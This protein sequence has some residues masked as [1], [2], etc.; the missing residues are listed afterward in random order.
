[1]KVVVLFG[2]PGSGKGTQAE[3]LA[4]KFQ[5]K[6]V[7]TGDLFR[8]NK[9]NNTELGLEAKPYIDNG[10][11]APDELTTKMLKDELQ[12]NSHQ[13]GFI[14]DGYPR[15]TSQ[16][17]ALDAILKELFQTEVNVTLA[18]HVED[19]TL[20]QRILKRGI[21][22]GRSDDSDENTIR[23]R[24]KEYYEKTAIVSSYYKDQ[25]KLVELEGEGSIDDITAALSGEIEKVI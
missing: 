18:L 12:R 3:V 19:E 10:K 7:S 23:I 5:L 24:I 4:K 25:D 6:H 8:Y 1:M 17:E 21:T 13:K 22:S 15:T 2:P 11:L 9:E 14:L 20:V 16:A